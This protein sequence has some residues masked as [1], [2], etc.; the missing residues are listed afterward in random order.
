MAATKE[1]PIIF[2][3]IGA[4]GG[5]WSTNTYKTRLTLN[6]K[7]LPYRVEFIDFEKVEQTMKAMGILPTSKSFP[8]YTLPMIADPTNDPNERPTFVSESFVI[9]AYL[10]DK[11]P[12]PKY[13]AVLPANTRPLQK[14]FIDRYWPTVAGPFLSLLYPKAPAILDENAREYLYQSRGKDIFKPLS[15]SEVDQTLEVARQNLESFSDILE[16]SGG[17]ASS[18]MMGNSLTFADFA[19]GTLLFFAHKIEGD[20]SRVLQELMGWQHGRWARLWK[21]INELEKNTTEVA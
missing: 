9:A 15:S 8:H 2:Y 18:F 14:V 12:S 10:D 1:N 16:L 11:Y 20:G 19:V 21:E 5:Y 13:P 7:R 3:D 4:P 17:G 6:Y